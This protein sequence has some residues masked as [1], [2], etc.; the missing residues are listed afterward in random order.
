MIFL[1][2]SLVAVVGGKG[3]EGT[4][5]GYIRASLGDLDL[6]EVGASDGDPNM[7]S[8][9]THHSPRSL[10][11]A[12]VTKPPGPSP[13]TSCWTCWRAS[14]TVPAFSAAFMVFVYAAQTSALVVSKP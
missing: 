8:R 12:L 7:A 1:D 13:D 9:P 11:R 14:S 3:D 2:S 5:G 6:V 10:P 4:A